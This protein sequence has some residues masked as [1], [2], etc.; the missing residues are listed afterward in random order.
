MGPLSFCHSSPPRH[1]RPPRESAGSS[2]WFTRC[3]D[4]PRA[5]MSARRR[6]KPAERKNALARNRFVDEKA[7]VPA[8]YTMGGHS[9]R[10]IGDVDLDDVRHQ[11]FGAVC[12]RDST[13]RLQHPREATVN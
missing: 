2:V 12:P 5:A 1:R 11:F 13:G 4:Q 3:D 6:V 10:A 7:R 9:R 8:A